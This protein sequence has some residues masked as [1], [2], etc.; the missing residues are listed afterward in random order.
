MNDPHGERYEGEDEPL[1]CL[2]DNDPRD[3]CRG[4]IQLRCPLTSTGRAFPRCDHH[5]DKRLAR[6]QEIDHRYPDSDLPPSDFDP[7]YA[8]ERWNE[9]D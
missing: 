2:D 8:G 5:W 7:S 4:S 9:D 1:E 6:Q 3:P